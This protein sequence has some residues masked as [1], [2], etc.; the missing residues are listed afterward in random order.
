MGQINAYIKTEVASVGKMLASLLSNMDEGEKD[1]ASSASTNFII[2]VSKK[3]LLPTLEPLLDSFSES[4]P[5]RF[6]VVY[7]DQS[8]QK[9]EAEISA[10]CHFYSHKE[11][12]C[13]EIIRFGATRELISGVSNAIRSNALG[14]MPSDLLVFDPGISA[15]DLSFFL[16]LIDRVIY[17]SSSMDTGTIALLSDSDITSVD[18]DW[19]RI[20]VWRDEIK[21]EFGKTT[22]LSS[23]TKLSKVS[24]RATSPDSALPFCAKLLAAWIVNRIGLKVGEKGSSGYKCL[25]PDGSTIDLV[26]EGC[27]G[28]DAPRIDELTMSFDNGKYIRL[29]RGERLET[30]VSLGTSYKVSRSLR[31][32]SVSGCFTRFFL[33]GESITNY[34]EARATALT[35]K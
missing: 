30:E 33:I 12:T 9:V 16:P 7:F 1:Y 14:G 24:I 20:S 31:D 26:I 10:R 5:S 19:I 22:L 6:F 15:K 8:L 17:D 23:L 27:K 25:A 4:Y 13:S 18:L 32:E 21:S 11:R 29:K 34:S 2:L 28:G 3:E 35:F